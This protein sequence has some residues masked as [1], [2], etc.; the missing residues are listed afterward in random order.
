MSNEVK[1]QTEGKE[2]A[3]ATSDEE[4]A[5]L[6][7]K[8]KELSAKENEGDGVKADYILLAKQGTKSLKVFPLVISF[9]T[10]K[11]RKSILVLHSKLYHL[12]SLHCIR[13]EMVQEEMPVSLVYG[14][15]NRQQLTL[16]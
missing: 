9:L 8:S 16:L 12:L 13:K 1:S 7:A 3:Q 14:I 2:V 5:L 15:K 4:L 10:L 11:A 6:L